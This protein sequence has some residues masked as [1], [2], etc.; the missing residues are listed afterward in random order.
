[1]LVEL[2]PAHTLE[3]TALDV[4][5]HPITETHNDP[6][7]TTFPT[8]TSSTAD[9]SL[10]LQPGE[11]ILLVVVVVV[12]VAVGLSCGMQDLLASCRMFSLHT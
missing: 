7:S 12:V 3:E 11:H 1:M 5:D 10:F 9:P 8:S 6:V 4:S 2:E